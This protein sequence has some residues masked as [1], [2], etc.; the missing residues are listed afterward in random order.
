M[1][2]NGNL[3]KVTP[4]STKEPK[5]V[6]LLPRTL[7]ETCDELA[8]P[9]CE[10][11]CPRH[12]LWRD[13]NLGDRAGGEVFAVTLDELFALV[14][15]L[16]DEN[17]GYRGALKEILDWCEG[18]D[19]QAMLRKCRDTAIVATMPEDFIHSE[20]ERTQARRAKRAG[21]LHDLFS[22]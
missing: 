21:E 13:R 9:I 7:P 12:S 16:E 19:P 6:R 15:R 11:L 18:D 14:A 8:Y 17:A 3:Q 4:T 10:R 1:R 22:V 5:Y 2:P 20:W